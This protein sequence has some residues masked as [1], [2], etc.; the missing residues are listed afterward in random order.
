MILVVYALSM[1][2]LYFGLVSVVKKGLTDAFVDE[3][4]SFSRVIADNLEDLI[5]STRDV[6]DHDIIEFLDGVVLGGQSNYAVIVVDGELLESSLLGNLGSHNFQEDFSFGTNGDSTYYVSLPLVTGRSMGILRLGFDEM[7]IEEHVEQARLTILYVMLAYLAAVVML[8]IVLSSRMVGPIQRLKYAS[9]QIASGDYEK[10]LDV[11]SGVLEIRELARDLEKMRGNLVGINA[12]LKSE[13]AERESAV[14]GKKSLESKLRHAQRLE[15]LGTLA[16]GVAHEF[17]N[18]LQ[19]LMLYTDLAIEDIPDDSPARRHLDRVLELA[20]DAKGLS[21]QILTFGRIGGEAELQELNLAPIVD[22]ALAM[23]SALLPATID[24]K[25]DI[26]ADIGLVNCD[27]RQI[28]QLIVNLCS[29]AFQSLSKGSGHI[30]LRYF[31]SFVTVDEATRHHG[32]HAGDY[33][34][35][36]VS[37][38]GVGMDQETMRRIFEP[39]YTTQDVGEGTGLGLSVVHGI[40]VR[41]GG[42]IVVE[43]KEGEGSR[44]RV[45][46]P[47]A[48]RE[49]SRR[50]AIR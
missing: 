18:V 11:H 9:N 28:Q 27:Q 50:Q 24:I 42:G 49:K 31:H 7:P 1:P 33:A 43:S 22:E 21:Q 39:F 12:Q 23:V 3:V 48:N 26:D 14:A 4:R 13:I 10:T 20:Y 19:P 15:S 38:T 25:S 8:T 6:E 35:I 34:V 37:D 44:F 16:G 2:V 41:H 17:N 40:V 5:G 36:E 45:Y 46:L 32:L 47:I 29:N 30:E